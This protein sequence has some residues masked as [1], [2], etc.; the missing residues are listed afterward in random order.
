M[1]LLQIKKISLS[2]YTLLRH[3]H[4]STHRGGGVLLYVKEYLHPVQVHPVNIFPE[5]IWRYITTAAGDKLFIG[6]CYK[7]PSTSIYPFDL[8][9]SLC[10][11][12]TEFSNK[13]V[14]LMG[15]F[16]FPDIDWRAHDCSAGASAGSRQFLDCIS[17]N[18]L[19]Q[20]VDFP[21]RKSSVLDIL[22]SSNPDLIVD[23]KCLGH[24]GS[25]VII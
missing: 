3:D 5:Q 7:T 9:T 24:L 11:M 15:D 16:N 13:S 19:T 1:T 23:I 4:S 8:N 21:T 2:G 14:I 25:I 6:I 17:N 12:I 18:F 20:H 10:D 22:F